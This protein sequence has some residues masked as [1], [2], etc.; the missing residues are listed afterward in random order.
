MTCQYGG[1]MGST[2]TIQRQKTN[3]YTVQF[4]GISLRVNIMVFLHAKDAKVSLNGAFAE[5]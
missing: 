4:V 3:K 1:K 5:T 2:K